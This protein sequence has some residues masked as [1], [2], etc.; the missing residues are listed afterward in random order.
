MSLVPLRP[1]TIRFASDAHE[2]VQRAA[3]EAG[4][5]FSDFV[6]Q[7]A[8][9][10][11]FMMLEADLPFRELASEV[12]VLSRNVEEGRVAAR[13]EAKAAQPAERAE[14]RAKRQAKAAAKRQAKP[15]KRNH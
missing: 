9:M 8:T 12:M 4:V 5:P 11:A 15:P 2:V 7:A 14:R 3:D 1:V 13:A 6:R 10:R